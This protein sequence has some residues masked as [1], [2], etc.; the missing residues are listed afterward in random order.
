MTIKRLAAIILICAA[1]T[2]GLAAQRVPIPDTPAGRLAARYIYSFNSGSEDVMARFFAENVGEAARRL[3]SDEE[4][5]RFYRRMWPRMGRL[6]VSAVSESTET[7]LTLLTSAE[8][9]GWFTFSF[10]LEPKP[11]YKL[12][13]IRIERSEPPAGDEQV[14]ALPPDPDR[15]RSKLDEFLA[16]AEAFGYS[17]GVLVALR[18]TVLVEKGCGLA[19]R[20]RRIP[21]GPETAFDIGSNTKDFTKTVILRLA[22]QGR[23]RLDDPLSK[24]FPDA[25]PDKAGITIAELLGHTAG[26]KLYSGPDEEALPRDEFLKRVFATDLLA[27]PGTEI[28][29][30]NPGYSLLAAVIETV[31]G[32][33]YEACLNDLIFKPAGMT[34]TGYA[35]TKWKPGQIAHSYSGGQDRGSTLDYPHAPDGPYWNLRGNGGT[36][37]TLGDMYKFH[38][39]FEDGRLL[40]PDTRALLFP[41]DRPVTLVGG[42]GIHF[43]VYY[44][45]PALGLA[46]FIASTD[47]SQRAM[48]LERAIV[49][50]VRGR[51]VPPPPRVVKL[52]AGALAKCAG[53]YRLGPEAGLTVA[54][55][56]EGL[57][58]AAEGQPAISL[59][60]GL[61]PD[62][63]DRIRD[64]NGR[65]QAIS[66]AAARNDYGPLAKALGPEAPLPLAEIE[67][68]ED[69]VRRQRTEAFGAERGFRVL[70]TVVQTAARGPRTTQSPAEATT[71]VRYDFE[72]G[73]AYTLF[74][75]GEDSLVGIR[76]QPTPPTVMFLPQSETEFAAYDLGAQ[77]TTRIAFHLDAGGR[78]KALR[79]LSAPGPAEAQRAE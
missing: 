52:P 69:A 65:A 72:R 64:L 25:P 58:L 8:K 21:F 66:E 37:A 28:N 32:Q 22:E 50:I 62:Q 36:L 31:T 40:R 48:D 45:E 63:A 38:L 71:V 4:R 23:L 24:Y 49:P 76:P 70:G 55:E 13:E 14:P 77:R 56:G 39:A 19:D 57:A 59:L 3:R 79:V 2:G 26:F 18:G 75:W 73:S 17:G 33:S 47:A 1:A 5:L 68:R 53:V 30:S 61:G 6:T 46:V 78:V 51:D 67:K 7:A 29:Y 34:E 43:F 74:I 9:G 60:A 35:L 27:R 16:G 11:S 12:D 41:P 44:R 54:V 42:N 15:I 10:Q 20:D